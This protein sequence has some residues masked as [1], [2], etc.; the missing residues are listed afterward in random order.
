[1]AG[2]GMLYAGLVMRTCLHLIGADAK[3]MLEWVPRA[4]GAT[5]VMALTVRAVQTGLPPVTGAGSAALQLFASGAVGALA[6]PAALYGLW[7]ALGQPSGP[8][9]TL[10]PMIARFLPGRQKSA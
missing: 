4:L 2:M 7:R 10:F 3:L 1:M 5:L 8:E 6:C 9:S